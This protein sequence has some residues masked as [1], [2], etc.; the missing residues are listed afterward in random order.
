M[1]RYHASLDRLHNLYPKLIDLSL[2]RLER[3]LADLGSPHLRL[4]PVIHV[5]GTNGKGSTCAFMR[6]IA[7]AAGLKVHIYT[8]PH[9][10]TFNERIRLAGELVS[11]AALAEA[12]DEIE[13]KNAGN[14][15]TVFEAI[16]A[17]AF[18]LFSRAPADL[19]ILEV[20]LGGKLD[21]TNVIAAPKVA[22]I[23]S[24]SMDHQDFLG[25]RLEM[26][27]AEKAG[28]IKPGCIVVTGLQAPTAL[29][30][31]V[32]TAAAAAA[33]LRLRGRDWE[34]T[35]TPD[36]LRFAGMELPKPAL[37]G[38]HQ[39]DNAGI[40][41]AALQAS[42]LKFPASAYAAGLHN[43]EW[44]AR[45]QR[46]HGA[47]LSKLPAGSELWLDGA[48]NPGGGQALAAQL[49]AW[50]SPTVLLVGMKQSKDVAEFITPL[51]TRAA[52]IFAVVELGQHLALPI[53]KIIAASR[54]IAVPGPD[55]AGAMAQ[56]HEPARV[57]ICG[58]LYLA[59]EV[60]KLDASNPPPPTST[61][62]SPSAQEN[63]A[64]PNKTSRKE[65]TTGVI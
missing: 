30:E 8:S 64:N 17:A 42:G 62:A 27:A 39:A 49:D 6:A 33:P 52:K 40:A 2:G 14:Q 4:P 16:T 44:P 9:L 12:L 24:I 53:E 23:T 38:E 36:G 59:G 32:K 7:E 11:D 10:V 22:A 55:V 29:D 46:L 20:G 18:L 31:I 35:P 48:H 19:C 5:A 15:I 45:L 21:A 47:L 28:I 37:L 1:S 25:A 60:L 26:I 3:L 57:L 13:S 34:V 51:L 43:A 50:G 56:I 54:G 65:D 63:P 58:S 61:A 41:M